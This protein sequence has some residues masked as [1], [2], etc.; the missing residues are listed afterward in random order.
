MRKRRQTKDL[1][2]ILILYIERVEIN[3][4]LMWNISILLFV[5]W[6]KYKYNQQA[7]NNFKSLSNFKGTERN[8]FLGISILIFKSGMIKTIH[9]T[10]NVSALAKCWV[11]PLSRMYMNQKTSYPQDPLKLEILVTPL[12]DWQLKQVSWLLSWIGPH[13]PACSNHTA[14]H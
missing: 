3:E 10:Q 2:F 9:L 14:D 6:Y 7:E 1:W 4:H 12:H 5:K 13:L 11:P 8:W